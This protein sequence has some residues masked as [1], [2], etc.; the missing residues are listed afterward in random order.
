[1]DVEDTNEGLTISGAE[2]AFLSRW[3]DPED[4][5]S[6]SEEG[7]N[8][9]P[10]KETAPVDEE[11]AEVEEETEE[12][13]GTDEDQSEDAAEEKKPVKF[14][15]DEDAQVKIVVDGEEHTASIKD[16]KRF[17]GQEA[18]LTRK[19]QEVAEVRKVAEENAK[20]HLVGL[21]ALLERAEKEYEPFANLDF[22]LAAKNLSDED[23][24]AVREA[25]EKAHANV[26]FFT[27]ELSG[28]MQGLETKRVED[29]KK[30]AAE[31]IKA[32]ENPETG[33]KGWNREAYDSLKDYVVTQGMPAEVYMDI[34]NPVIFRIMHKA[35]Q[36]DN[37][38]K[39]STQK[40]AN[41]P[42]KVL[43]S[44]G[45]LPSKKSGAQD[46][47]ALKVLKQRGDRDSA[48]NAF[49]ARW[50]NSSDD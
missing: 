26:R 12:T 13:E 8:S 37:I 47:S 17:Y 15:E 41:A 49:M 32:L 28:M 6:K 4:Q 30:A 10:E 39:L 24:K 35:Q 5:A 22:N 33:I 34:T 40:K 11:I 46:L 20:V 14:V 19:S 25:A 38:K 18:S 50:D 42:K 2:D 23:Y 1:M 31:C 45:A 16:L 7:A 29:Y 27:E 48:A 43:K 36:F 3:T 44:K 21:Q 9:K